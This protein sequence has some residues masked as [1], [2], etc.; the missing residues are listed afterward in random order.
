MFE[1]ISRGRRERRDKEKGRKYFRP[2]A[3]VL[4]V[5]G[6]Y[7]TPR[8]C[9]MAGSYCSHQNKEKYRKSVL[10]FVL[11]TVGENLRSSPLAE[12]GEGSDKGKGSKYFRAIEN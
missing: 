11:G 9:L 10:L 7:A 12:D 1:S 8:F 6:S 2:N 5:A 3:K 4:P